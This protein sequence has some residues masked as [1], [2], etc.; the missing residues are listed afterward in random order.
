L[1]STAVR[2]RSALQFAAVGGDGRIAGR[3]GAGGYQKQ[4]VQHQGLSRF[5]REPRCCSKFRQTQRSMQPIGTT[6]ANAQV[7][8][9][10][11]LSAARSDG[12]DF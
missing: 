9:G 6:L 1:A 4:R 3:G 10:E 2:A 5:K 12:I 11:I 7:T 8:Y